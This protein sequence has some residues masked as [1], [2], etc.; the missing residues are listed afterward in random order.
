MELSGKKII[1]VGLGKSGVSSATFLKKRGANVI[2]TDSSKDKKLFD[3]AGKLQK[4]GIAVE[5]GYHDS[6]SFRDSEIIV[7]SPG[8]PHTIEPVVNAAKN[9]ASIIGE[10]ELASRFI[11]EPIVAITGTNGKTTT[12]ILT[13]KMLEESG[14]K[15]FVGGNIGNPLIDYVD[16]GNKADIVVAEISSFQLDTIEYFSPKVS[17][18]LNITEDHLDRYPDF[19]AYAKSKMRIF[20]NQKDGDYAVFNASDKHIS[21]MAKDIKCRILPFFN[22]NTL[23]DYNEFAKIADDRIVFN[24]NNIA[25]INSDATNPDKTFEKEFSLPFSGIHL[26]GKHNMENVAAATLATL[27]AGGNIAGIKSALEKFKSLPHRIEHVATI[28]GVEYYNDSKATTVDSVIKALEVFNKPVILIMGGRNKGSNF[29]LLAD[30]AKKHVKRLILIG[31]SKEEIKSSLGGIVE[32]TLSDSLE[33]A[34]VTAS[35]FAETDEVVLLSPACSSFDM[36]TSYA[37]RGETFRNAVKS[38]YL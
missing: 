5:L 12:T 3:A 16:S 22:H 36:F 20:I 31:E 30:A 17:V 18:L 35:K 1:V 19:N 24:I 29:A 13:G 27:A 6:S 25:A 8:V 2:V 10:I 33:N 15:V 28:N 21:L 26:L 37:H 9:G 23:N 4:I 32:T 14:L 34:V 7:L 11:K 38:L